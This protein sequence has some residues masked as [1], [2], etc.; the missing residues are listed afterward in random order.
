MTKVAFLVA[1]LGPVVSLGFAFV[2]GQTT[3]KTTWDGVYTEAQ[4]KRGE[5]L[6]SQACAGCHAPDLSGADAAPSLTGTAFNAEWNDLSVADLADRIRTTMPADAPGSLSRQQYVDIVTFI[7]AKD[8]FPVGPSELPAQDDSLK[9]IKIA[10]Q[11][12]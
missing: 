11:K 6:Y 2:Q 3:P 9:Q 8:G 7:L 5:E 1:V 12:P 10:T 4:A